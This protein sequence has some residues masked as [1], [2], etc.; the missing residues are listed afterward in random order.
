VA[1]GA[2]SHAEQSSEWFQSRFIQA[3]DTRRCARRTCDAA[4]TAAQHSHQ[5]F[6]ARYQPALRADPPT[7]NL[8]HI[9]TQQRQPQTVRARPVLIGKN[10]CHDTKL[11]FF[12]CPYRRLV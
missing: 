4:S 2:L 9:P 11:F 10:R 12:P 7:S 1:V 5:A 8:V 3:G 6:W